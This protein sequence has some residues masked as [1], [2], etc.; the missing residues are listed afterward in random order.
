[1]FYFLLSCF[2]FICFPFI[3]LSVFQRFSCFPFCVLKVTNK[4]CLTRKCFRVTMP[5]PTLSPCRF[6]YHFRIS[7]TWTRSTTSVP[8]S[9][10]SRRR[11]STRRTRT[12]T[13]RWPSPSTDATTP[14]PQRLKFTTRFLTRWFR[15][16]VVAK[17]K[18]DKNGKR[19]ER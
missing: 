14:P 8:S 9:S 3:C 18:R 11:R 2:I 6:Y 13:S 16:D 15:W 4:L 10:R 12:R 19:G 17:L 7:C 5:F 1:M